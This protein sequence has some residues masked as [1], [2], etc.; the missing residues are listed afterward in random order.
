MEVEKIHKYELFCFIGF[1]ICFFIY[2]VFGIAGYAW[3]SN[4]AIIIGALFL[5][6]VGVLTYMI[7]A[8]KNNIEKEQR[9]NCIPAKEEIKIFNKIVDVLKDHNRKLEELNLRIQNLETTII[10]TKESETNGK[11][12][13]TKKTVK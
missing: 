11:K 13:K 4:I 10:K 6:S 2:L 7:W 5:I 3:I 8:T 12:T 9:S 1:G